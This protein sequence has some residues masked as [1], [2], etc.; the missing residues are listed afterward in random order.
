LSSLKAPPQTD[1]VIIIIPHGD[2]LRTI[3]MQDESAVNY[4]LSNLKTIS[5]D[6]YLRC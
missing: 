6:E 3:L 2:A 1:A 5:I 4:Y